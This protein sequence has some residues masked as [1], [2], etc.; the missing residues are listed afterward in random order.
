M[1]LA[2]V[3]AEAAFQQKVLSQLEDYFEIYVQQRG[4]HPSGRH[5]RIDAIAVPRDPERWSR[6]DIALGIEFKAPSLK[7]DRKDCAKIISQCIDYSLATWN[8]FGQLPIFFCPGFDE[9]NSLRRS[10][11]LLGLQPRDY[12]TGFGDGIG[13]LMAAMLGQNNVGELIHTDHLGWAFMINGH[14]R[15]WSERLG[16]EPAGVGEAKHNK[17]IR[18]I[19]SR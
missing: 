4:T 7:R 18:T 14:H 19:G 1:P 6:P 15:L 2:P 9:T 13:Y 12:N 17:L 16:R 8:E 10:K 3:G 5:L 11:D